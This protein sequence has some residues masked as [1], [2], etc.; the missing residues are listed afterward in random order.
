MKNTSTTSK[1]RNTKKVTTKKTT[2][3]KTSRR[4]TSKKV[5]IPKQKILLMCLGVIAVC[6]LLLFVTNIIDSSS[7]PKES[8]PK[9]ETKIE[10]PV[11]EE[12]KK[13]AEKTEVPVRTVEPVTPKKED[14]TVQNNPKPLPPKTEV[15]IPKKEDKP[16]ENKKIEP[17]APPAKPKQENTTTITPEKTLDFG[18]PKAVNNA[19]LVF[20]F[21]DGG[22]NLSHLE[23]FL[24]LPFPITVAVLPRLTYSKASA[25]KVRASGNELMLHQPMQALNAA[26]NPGPGAI[27]PDM[28]EDEII[29]TLFQNINEIGPIDGMNN[30]EGS[31]ITA[32][33]EKMATVLKLASE[34]GIFFLDSRTNKDTKV[35]YVSHELGYSYYERN[36]NFLDNVKTR[37]NALTEIKKNLDIANKNGVVI[38][39]GHVW[40]ADFLPQ[41]LK[42]IYPELKSKGY[43]ITTVSKSRGQKK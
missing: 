38:M 24:E 20:I 10:K 3:R 27:K 1:N 9:Q 30:H 26:V 43:V 18:F 6:M 16:T 25:Q 37:E 32:D 34:N 31:A 15:E 13:E 19:Q 28:S 5:Y 2:N 23:K 7:Q 17:P 36:G 39:I 22:Q 14:K 40:S 21:D 42:E 33:E 12:K 41:L 35:P 11:T 4:S 29:A 8:K